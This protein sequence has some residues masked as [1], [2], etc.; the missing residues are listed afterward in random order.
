VNGPDGEFVVVHNGIITNHA[1]LKPFLVRGSGT[2]L[3]L[4]KTRA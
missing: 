2:S 3:L 1:T 4:R